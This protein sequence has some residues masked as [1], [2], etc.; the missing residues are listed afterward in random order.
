MAGFITSIVHKLRKS[1][2]ILLSQV[3]VRVTSQFFSSNED[4]PNNH[5]NLIYP[6]KE[7]RE[8]GINNACISK[9]QEN[10]NA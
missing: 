7:L 6:F 5:M 3:D 10:T 2:L 1:T 9:E 8:D 4:S